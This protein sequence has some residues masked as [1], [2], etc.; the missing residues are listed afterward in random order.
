MFAAGYDSAMSPVG[1]DV[2]TRLMNQ[3]LPSNIS[4]GVGDRYLGIPFA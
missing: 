1:I 3:Q 2:C 4:R